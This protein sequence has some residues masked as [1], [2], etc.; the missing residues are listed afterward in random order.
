MN[1]PPTQWQVPDAVRDLLEEQ[2]PGARNGSFRHEVRKAF[3]LV[4]Q[5]QTDG[6]FAVSCQTEA[7]AE[8]VRQVAEILKREVFRA[9]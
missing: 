4:L 7:Q 8:C 6:V 5:W 2:F 3:C 1:A 9:S